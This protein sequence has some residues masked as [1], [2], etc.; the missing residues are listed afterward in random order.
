MLASQS[1]YNRLLFF[2]SFQLLFWRL[3][4]ICIGRVFFTFI[5]IC[6]FLTTLGV[7]EIS[8]QC[9]ANAHARVVGHPIHLHSIF[10]IFSS[11]NLFSNLVFD[12][13]FFV[14]FKLDF[15]CCVACKNP[16]QNRQ[17]NQVQKSISR[18]RDFK[19]SSTDR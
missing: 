14:H 18:N 9:D 19:K 13:L 8:V 7:V 5:Q 3:L 15:Y 4:V 16:V 1:T 11:R 12:T 17:K 2:Y 10:E 6:L